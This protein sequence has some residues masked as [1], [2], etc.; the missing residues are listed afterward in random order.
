MSSK[1]RCGRLAHGVA[2]GNPELC[3]DCISQFEHK[4]MFS[5]VSPYIN[6]TLVESNPDLKSGQNTPKGF[7]PG[8][9]PNRS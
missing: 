2:C 4:E 1:P 7:S 3:E 9:Y 6:I 5:I 8:F